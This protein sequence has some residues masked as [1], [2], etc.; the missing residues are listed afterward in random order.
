[1]VACDNRDVEGSWAVL[2]LSLLRVARLMRLYRLLQVRWRRPSSSRA[3]ER[4]HCVS[5]AGHHAW[6]RATRTPSRVFTAMCR[7]SQLQMGPLGGRAA[8]L[9]NVSSC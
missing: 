2:G 4:S 1:V 8:L 7:L 3:A 9:R 5:G 6:G